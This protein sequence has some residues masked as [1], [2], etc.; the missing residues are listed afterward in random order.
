MAR[1]DQSLCYFK[2]NEADKRSGVDFR[3]GS[4][5]Y[6]L[7]QRD[8]KNLNRYAINNLEYT[9]K[10]SKRWKLKHIKRYGWPQKKL[11]GTVAENFSYWRKTTSQH[12]D[13]L[14]IFWGYLFHVKIKIKRC[15]HECKTQEVQNKV[16][17]TGD[18]QEQKDQIRLCQ[19]KI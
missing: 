18:I 7:N 5:G 8:S 13:K 10:E 16:Q 2:A 9:F 12:G 4:M 11:K 14:R 6:K 15:H 1:C 17:A 3:C 19:K